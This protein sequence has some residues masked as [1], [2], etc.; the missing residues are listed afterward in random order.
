MSD[1][2]V[3]AGKTNYAV[4]WTSQILR[5]EYSENISTEFSL[6]EIEIDDEDYCAA[7]FY[8][9][10]FIKLYAVCGRPRKDND[11]I[12]EVIN[13]KTLSNSTYLFPCGNFIMALARPQPGKTEPQLGYRGRTKPQM[14]RL[15]QPK[16]TSWPSLVPTWH[17]SFCES[18]PY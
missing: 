10:K 9:N 11:K 4:K 5:G 16:P 14:K 1:V 18:Q 7:E 13:Y 17:R 8:K 15:T 12:L 6:M 3:K 2:E